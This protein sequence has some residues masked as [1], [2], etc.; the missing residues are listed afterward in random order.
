[1]IPVRKCGSLLGVIGWDFV[2]FKFQNIFF[3]ILLNSIQVLYRGPQVQLISYTRFEN[4]MSDH[5]PIRASF[6]VGTKVVQSQ[7]YEALYEQMTRASQDYV[8]ERLRE[9]YIQWTAHSCRES[10]QE[11]LYRLDQCHW[12]MNLVFRNV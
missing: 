11:A 3:L 1:M 10:Y 5:K 6:T 9:F 2:S 12:D 8:N 4:K 7:K